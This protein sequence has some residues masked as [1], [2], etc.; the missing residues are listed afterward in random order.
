MWS[1]RGRGSRLWKVC[2]QDVSDKTG[3]KIT[4]C[5]FPPGTSEWNAIEHRM[6]CHISRNWCGRP[7]LSRAIVVNLIVHTTT[8][9]GL[10]IAAFDDLFLLL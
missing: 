10:S 3:L 2:L 5:H 1:N 8:T 7:L 6:F 4:D 9:K